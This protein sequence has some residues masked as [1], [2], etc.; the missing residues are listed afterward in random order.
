MFP[1]SL[2]VVRKLQYTHYMTR[3][4]QKL[5]QGEDNS[6]EIRLHSLLSYSCYLQAKKGRI[7]IYDMKLLSKVVSL[8]PWL[9]TIIHG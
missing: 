3:Y 5:K 9:E 6:V 1:S 8:Y 2:T 4:V 7:G